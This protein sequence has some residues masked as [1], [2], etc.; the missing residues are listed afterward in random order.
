MGNPRPV[1]G[2]RLSV[3][4]I[5]GLVS[6]VGA[7]F[8]ETSVI[9]PARGMIRRIRAGV[10]AGTSINQV[11]LEVR[12]VAGGTSL[13]IVG[14]YPLTTNPLDSDLS[15]GPIF[16]T[17]AQTG[18]LFGGRSGSLF[19]AVKVDNATVDHTVVL[20]LDIEATE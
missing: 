15:G 14:Q 4:R 17:V 11:A 18:V 10:S 7:V 16:Y 20:Y 2:N 3:H 9:V 1:G 19:I 8:I 5:E 12:E 6:S 13:D